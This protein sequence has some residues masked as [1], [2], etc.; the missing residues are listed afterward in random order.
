MTMQTTQGARGTRADATMGAETD[1]DVG[2]EMSIKHAPDGSLVITHKPEGATAGAEMGAEPITAASVKTDATTVAATATGA[3]IGAVAGGPPGALLGLGI[4]AAVDWYRHRQKKAKAAAAIAKARAAVAAANNPLAG[5]NLV[6]LKPIT[7][8]AITKAAPPAFPK[9]KL[10]KMAVSA[11]TATDPATTN[12][13]PNT[14]AAKTAADALYAYFQQYPFDRMLGDVFWKA[15]KTGVLTK[16]FQ[17]AY[18]D[19]KATNEATGPLNVSGLYDSKT[20][21]ALT[22]YTHNPID[23]DPNAG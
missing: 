7:M 22:F 15:A 4:G 9:L 21:G 12:P 19:D 13:D 11:K 1:V 20:A 18:N 14:V 10:I 8:K 17:T 2:G 6:N 5:L 16:A 3:A 23:P